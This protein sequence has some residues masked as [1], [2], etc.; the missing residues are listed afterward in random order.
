MSRSF[1][2]SRNFEGLKEVPG[3]FRGGSEKFQGISDDF[4]LGFRH[5]F[6]SSLSGVLEHFMEFKLFQ[7]RLKKIK[8][9]RGDPKHFRSKKE[10]QEI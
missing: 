10:M 5:G 2:V 1:S 7:K 3:D 9:F 6:C 4:R 8:T